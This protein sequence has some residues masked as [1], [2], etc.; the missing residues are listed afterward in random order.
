MARLP[1]RATTPT[2]LLLL[3]SGA[4]SGAAACGPSAVHIDVALSAGEAAPPALFASVY[5]RFGALARDRRFDAPRLPGQIEIWFPDRDQT[6][7]VALDGGP[8]SPTPRG[9][10]TV[11]VR[12]HARSDTQITLSAAVADGDGDRVPDLVDNCPTV[13]NPDQADADG[14]GAGDACQGGDGGVPPSTC[15]TSTAALCD[16]FEDALDLTR[17]RVLTQG[18][19]VTLDGTRAYRGQQSV[20]VALSPGGVGANLWGLLSESKTF[21]AAQLHLRAW[22]YL[23][24]PLPSGT[25]HYGGLVQAGKDVFMLRTLDGALLLVDYASNVD[26]TSTT[27]R[28]PV[29]RW[30]CVEWSV[31]NT[32]PSAGMTTTEL[33]AWL[34]GVEA[35]DVRFTTAAAP[36]D[37]LQLG[38][39]FYGADAVQPA[40]DLWIDEVIVDGAP[41]GCDK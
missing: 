1:T 29:G 37:E 11:A 27:A 21:P 36:V 22:L 39:A 35:G 17:W 14:D 20:H 6:V 18:A 12:P 8:A 19:S 3:V 31:S 33:R 28:L 41:I 5:D 7:R 9:A 26:R 25:A 23:A 4:V 40:H 30:V 10:A 2:L 13:P 15:A 38:L 24:A 32:A 16:G 34:D